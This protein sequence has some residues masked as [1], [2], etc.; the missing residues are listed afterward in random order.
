M[1]EALRI[2]VRRR[3]RNTAS[4]LWTLSSFL[5]PISFHEQ[6]APDVGPGR[7]QAPAHLPG[8]AYHPSR[9][10]SLRSDSCG[11][12]WHSRTWTWQRSVRQRCRSLTCSASHAAAT[13]CWRPARG[14]RRRRPRAS[15]R[16]CSLR[17]V[18][19]PRG[20]DSPFLQSPLLPLPHGPLP[21][22]ELVSLQGCAPSWAHD[23]GERGGHPQISA[24]QD[25]LSEARRKHLVKL[26]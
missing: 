26:S 11:R 12:T 22:A 8:A 13:R 14:Q 6:S 20:P 17:K 21:E 5:Q 24:P 9:S 19:P 18:S 23:C 4:S 1:S 10:C 7:V 15:W 3:V 16:S 25:Y 2:S